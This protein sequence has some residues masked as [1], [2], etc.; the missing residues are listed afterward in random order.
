MVFLINVEI[1]KT[2]RS[3]RDASQKSQMQRLIF[4]STTQPIYNIKDIMWAT[5]S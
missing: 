1:F 3:L 5:V 4:K 2:D